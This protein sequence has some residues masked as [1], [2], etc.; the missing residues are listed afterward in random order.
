[1]P[2]AVQPA[3]AWVF[4]YA[5]LGVWSIDTYDD[6][7]G[8][9]HERYFGNSRALRKDSGLVDDGAACRCE[10]TSCMR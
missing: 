9:G 7:H 3:F 10:G 8:I 2:R 4:A 5:G 6:R 1:M